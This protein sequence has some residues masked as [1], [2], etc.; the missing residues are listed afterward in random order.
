MTTRDTTLKTT[1]VLPALLVV[2]AL[3]ASPMAQASPSLASLLPACFGFVLPRSGVNIYGPPGAETILL[4]HGLF[5]TGATFQKV[6]P[7]LAQKYRV[8]TFDV[9]GYG[10]GPKRGNDY[11]TSFLAADTI[12]LMDL[13][14]IKKAHLLGHSLGGR[15]A[16][17]IAATYP[18]RVSSLV[19]EDIDLIARRP[20]MTAAQEKVAK[21]LE[22]LTR[23]LGDRAQVRAQLRRYLGEEGI[24]LEAFANCHDFLDE[25][26][27]PFDLA[28]YYRWEI[29]G[30]S[31]NLI[32]KAEQITAP[33][34][35]LQ[36]GLQGTATTPL[37]LNALQNAVP[38]LEL[39]LF[40]DS[41]HYI[42]EDRPAAFSKVVVGFFS[43]ASKRSM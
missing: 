15:V 23:Y 21:Q 43:R 28:A 4:M 19:V 32:Q 8:V 18:D 33:F 42:H 10:E 6:V 22:G 38:Q 29:Q 11:S 36:A 35:Y 16:V 37:G 3:L 17:Q 2:A 12:Q 1:G 41:G 5:D 7:L 14:K 9:R 24:F 34:L 25:C 30:N 13:L 39:A 31:E 20:A 26:R 40:T 27:M